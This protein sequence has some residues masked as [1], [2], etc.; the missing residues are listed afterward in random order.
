MWMSFIKTVQFS[1]IVAQITLF[2][3]L[4][5][6]RTALAIPLLVP[7]LCMNLLFQWYIMQKHN[8]IAMFL[9]SHECIEVDRKNNASGPMDYSFLIDE[10]KQPQLKAKEEVLP[11]NLSVAR[12]VEHGNDTYGTPPG[13]EAD[14]E[15]FNGDETRSSLIQGVP[16][17]S[18]N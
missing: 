16:L 4:A 17:T 8:T 5:L 7:L 14:L 11:D 2:G 15:D 10:Y 18:S 9:P 6:K 3:F 1:M 13:S 12:E